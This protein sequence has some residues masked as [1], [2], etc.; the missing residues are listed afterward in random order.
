LNSNKL[1]PPSAEKFNS[2]T[3]L[4][5][6]NLS[7]NEIG[8]AVARMNLSTTLKIL[9]LRNNKIQYTGFEQLRLAPGLTKLDLS[10]NDFSDNRFRFYQFPEGLLELNYPNAVY[11]ISIYHLH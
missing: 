11:Q 7:N 6:L 1:G 10:G 3:A 2:L 9:D 5:E 8:N 4:L